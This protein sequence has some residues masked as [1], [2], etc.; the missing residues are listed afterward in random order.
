MAQ[1]GMQLIADDAEFFPQNKRANF[2]G[3]LKS[4]QYI[5]FLRALF[6]GPAKFEF[7]EIGV[8]F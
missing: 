7:A 5:Y 2:S 4:G 3:S 1:I 8:N 6:H